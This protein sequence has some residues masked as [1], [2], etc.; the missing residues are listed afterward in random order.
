MCTDQID[1]DCDGFVDGADTDCQSACF[2]QGA[3]CSIN[4]DCCSLK[5][6]GGNNKTCK[7]ESTCTVTESPEVSCLDGLDNDCDGL[8][9]SADADC[10]LP[11]CGLK[12]DTCSVNSDCCSNKCKG[13]EGSKSCK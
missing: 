2:P 11:S 1:N 3:S 4:S 12:G 10:P 13:P 8:V 9:D 7:G 5:C 6:R